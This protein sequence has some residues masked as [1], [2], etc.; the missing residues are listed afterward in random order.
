MHRIA[1]AL[2]VSQLLCAHDPI[3]TKL[4]W[5]QEISRIV[6]NRCATCHRPR[7]N[8]PMSL[9][10]YED[11]RPWAKAIKEQVLNRQMPPWG[12][13]KGFGDFR[14]DESLTQD[15]IN[16]LAEWV[17]GGAPEGEAIYLPRQPELK[18]I[19][20][21][22]RGVF[23]RTLSG[24]VTLAGIRP[25]SSVQSSQVLAHLPDGSVIPLIWLREYKQSWNRVFVYREPISLP[26]GV[27]I[28]ANPPVALEYLIKPKTAK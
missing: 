3:S 21:T 23:T 10:T 6:Y 19:P 4:T 16:R 25:L 13:V 28:E 20:P 11:A 24:P 26:R 8:A 17:E 2:L 9:L 12:A 7:G 5:T 15:E 18:K 1:C 14:N 22:I 27:R